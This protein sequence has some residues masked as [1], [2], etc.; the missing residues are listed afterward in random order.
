MF[1]P[2]VYDNLKVVL[3][4]A[5]YDQDLEGDIT[6]SNRE[7]LVDLA[8]LRRVYRAE[9]H[10]KGFNEQKAMI[11]L[12]ADLTQLSSELL[13]QNEQAGCDVK[14]YFKIPIHDPQ[15]TCP[16]IHSLLKD[17]WEG[18]PAIEQKISYR[19]PNID[20]RYSNFIILDFK[21]RIT[22]DQTND[23]NSI[24]TYTIESL[25]KLKDLVADG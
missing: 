1:D 6:I 21:R 20:K 24:T 2:T 18:R 9:F 11:E 13:H 17:V 22:E 23:L 12:A 5:V 4:G 8:K 10:L 14:I 7:D 3:E 15:S 25:K 16:E 19:Y